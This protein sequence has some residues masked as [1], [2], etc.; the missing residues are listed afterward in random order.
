MK[1]SHK[2]IKYINEKAKFDISQKHGGH[3][4]HFSLEIPLSEGKDYS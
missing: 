4:S 2:M 1:F 3:F